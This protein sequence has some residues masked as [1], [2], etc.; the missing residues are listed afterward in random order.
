MK[1]LEIAVAE[2]GQVSVTEMCRGIDQLREADGAA[3][4]HVRF[5]LFAQADR[6]FAR[7]C[8]KLPEF[9]ASWLTRSFDAGHPTVVLRLAERQ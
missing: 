9:K 5:E 2:D 6:F 1:L 3:E 8:T 7:A 4:L